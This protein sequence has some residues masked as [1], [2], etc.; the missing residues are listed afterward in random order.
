MSKFTDLVRE[1]V[2]KNWFDFQKYT[3]KNYTITFKEDL[4]EQLYH[5]IERP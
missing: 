5:E 1:S 4:R 2:I 3:P